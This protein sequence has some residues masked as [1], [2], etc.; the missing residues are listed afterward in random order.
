MQLVRQQGR[1]QPQRAGADRASLFL[2]KKGRRKAPLSQTLGWEAG[3]Q[4]QAS[5]ISLSSGLGGCL[6]SGWQWQQHG[7]HGRQA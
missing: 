2:T 6:I 1:G 3:R 5:V 4:E 7:L